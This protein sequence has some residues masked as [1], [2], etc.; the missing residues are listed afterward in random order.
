MKA[1]RKI[2]SVSVKKILLFET[3]DKLRT[4]ETIMNSRKF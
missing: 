4:E 1:L 3:R 2:I